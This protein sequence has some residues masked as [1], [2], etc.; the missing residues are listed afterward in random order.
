MR[1][2]FRQ[3]ID[4]QKRIPVR[5]ALHDLLRIQIR[6][7]FLLLSRIHN[8]L[9]LLIGETVQNGA[10]AQPLLPRYRRRPSHLGPS[11]DV[12]HH[13]ALPADPDAGTDRK[14]A[15]NPDLTSDY[16]EI[17][18][19]RTAGNTG[20]GRHD[21]ASA[22]HDVVTDLHQIINHRSRTD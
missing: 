2:D 6:N 22:E 19:L 1:H 21:A 17:T 7:G 11:R 5:N 4:H 16:D 10:L 8:S 3:P 20:L 15:R 18:Q 9:V 13:T 12:A 14:M